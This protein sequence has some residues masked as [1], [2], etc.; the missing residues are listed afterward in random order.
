MQKLTLFLEANNKDA[1]TIYQWT[2]N[3][4]IIGH[5]ELVIQYYRNKTFDYICFSYG[6]NIYGKEDIDNGGWSRSK[7]AA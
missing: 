3:L 7:A 6:R 4:E 5:T 1:L 2:L